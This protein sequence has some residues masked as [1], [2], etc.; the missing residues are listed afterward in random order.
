MDGFCYISDMKKLLLLLLLLPAIA[1]GQSA[2]LPGMSQNRSE[3]FQPVQ[4][5]YEVNS[6]GGKEYELIFKVTIDD[7]WHVYS[8]FIKEGG[9]IP[10]SF[11]F[12]SVPEIEFLGL[13]EE[14]G[15]LETNFDPNWDLELKQFSHQVAFVQRVKLNSDN[16]KFGGYYEFMT[17]D[18][19]RC[20][21][22][23]YIE[24]D[25]ELGSGGTRFAVR[26]ILPPEGTN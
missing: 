12:D 2:S 10:T 14:R 24:I 1:F 20:L 21:P 5:E 4:W 17:C 3:M 16:V 13:V 8:Q 26:E 18:D 22:P 7:G 19:E 11:G 9:P 15:E 6:L 23:E 25:V